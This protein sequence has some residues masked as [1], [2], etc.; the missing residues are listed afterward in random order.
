MVTLQ[1]FKADDAYK[2]DWI[3]VEDFAGMLRNNRYI[4]E[5]LEQEGNSQTMINDTGSILGIIVLTQYHESWVD[6]SMFMAKSIQEE[7]GKDI[8]K[9]LQDIVDDLK[10]KNKRVSLN[11]KKS[12]EKLTK[13]IKHLGFEEEGTMRKYGWHGEDYVLYS[14]VKED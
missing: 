4:F 3:E 11:G 2:M 8:Y 6:I 9:A 1:P 12:N 14:I 13:L 7:F 5:Y 10:S